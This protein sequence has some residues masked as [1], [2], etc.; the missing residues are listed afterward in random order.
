MRLGIDQ[1]AGEEER[2]RLRCVVHVTWAVEATVRL[3]GKARVGG[4]A[5]GEFEDFLPSQ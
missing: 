2:C 4:L 3:D 1:A 5:Q